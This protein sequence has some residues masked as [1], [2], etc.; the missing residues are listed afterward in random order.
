MNGKVASLLAAAL[1][2][3]TA[4]WS[5]EPAPEV[6]PVPESISAQG[7]P[8]I[9]AR[10]V[11]DLLP[12]ENL[13]TASLA[14]WHPKERRLLIRTRFAES[15]QV[16]EVA[17][18][19]GSRTQ[20]TFYRDPIGNASYRPGDPEQLLYALNEGGAENFQFFML[21]RRTGRA[22]RFTDGTH[23][24]VSPV[25]SHDGKLLA[26]SSNARNGRDMDVYVAD[27][28]TPGSERRIAQVQGSWSPL[29]WS[30]D[31][32]RLLLSE[33]ISANESYIHW[34]DVN[35][36]DVAGGEV[37]AITPRNARKQD[38]TIS[39]QGGQWSTDGKSVYALSDRGSEFLRLVRLDA[40]TNAPAVLSGAVPWDVEEF[41]LSDDGRLLAFFTN[42][43]GISKLHLIDA[44]TGAGLPAPD[45]P[46]GVASSLLFRPGS[47]ELA[48]EVSWARSPSD[49]YSYDP[50][51]RRLERW[52][53]SEAGGL[54][55]ES[56]PLPELVHY[57]TFDKRTIPAFVYRPAA[58]RFK[59]RRPVYISIHGGPEGQ[60]RPLFLG[61]MNYLPAEMGVALIY[62][63]VR[64]SSG[65]GKSY[66][67]LDNGRLRE[68]SVKDIGAL[69]DWIATQPD[70]DPA[71]V[72]V[73][74]GSYGGYMS[75]AVM[76]F[77]SDRLCCGWDTVGISNF[78]TFL[79]NTQGYRQ[80]LRR[81]EY[82]DERDPQMRA[83]LEGIAP[84][85]RAKKITRPLLVSQ[86]AN[87][88]RVPL[89]E[90]DQIVAAVKS[91]GVPVWYLVAKDE[92]HGFGKKT[93]TD[94]QRAVL[95]EFVRRFL[96][97]EK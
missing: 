92:G 69:L 96:L 16:H 53:A 91:N 5:A 24:Y 59:G 30:P 63:D 9:P 57:T 25:W 23:R 39:Y 12:Y 66:L 84:A 42:E 4:A 43:D 74:G 18:P 6:L 41:R 46:A 34:I 72:M 8:A 14:D 49:V 37:H 86:G 48:F 28:A 58:D 10:A 1:L 65:Y 44:T 81:A 13:R 83:F 79:Q 50:D 87:D 21:D 27:P 89:A 61:S 56:F 71:R 88:P 32:R 47:H 52:T 17:M 94:Y 82:G 77:Y 85:N 60:A 38:P 22:R 90:S 3:T 80:D 54:N 68:D 19:M 36:V 75:L 95:F 45:L 97:A 35:A 76:T 33:F 7:V 93:N 40:A 62:P 64:G 73:A 11:E 67:K 78:V 26:Y 15:P 51:Q 2:L 55:P 31:N 70:L 29:D 20:L